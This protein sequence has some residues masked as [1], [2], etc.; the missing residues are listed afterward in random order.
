MRAR[1]LAPGL[2][3]GHAKEALFAVMER[4]LGPARARYSE[5]LAAPAELDAVLVD[6]ATRARRVA[7]EVV[8]R[9]RAACGLRAT[10]RVAGR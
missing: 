10:P 6:G 2:G 5:L 8:G 7:A 4:R 3:Y 1:Y 9:A